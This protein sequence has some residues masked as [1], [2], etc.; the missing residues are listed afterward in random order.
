MKNTTRQLDTIERLTRLS[1]AELQRKIVEPILR[2]E[3]FTAVRQTSGPNDKGKDLIAYKEELGKKK[4]YAIQI[5]KLRISGK[6]NSSQGLMNLITQLRQVFSEPVADPLTM[7]RRFVDRAI[8]ITPYEIDKDAL[9]SAFHAAAELE[10]KD[11]AIIDGPMLADMLTKH[12]AIVSEVFDQDYRYRYLLAEKV[13]KIPESGA[14]GLSH[15]LLLRGLYVNVALTDRD[16]LIANAAF[17]KGDASPQLVCATQQEFQHL[18]SECDS[19]APGTKIFV[20]T[21]KNKSIQEAIKREKERLKQELAMENSRLDKRVEFLRDEQASTDREI[22]TD[23]A[24]TSFKNRMKYLAEAQPRYVNI[25]SVVEMI[26]KDASVAMKQL[27]APDF[28][29]K[30]VAELTKVFKQLIALNKRIR[31]FNYQSLIHQ[32]WPVLWRGGS[33]QM[34]RYPA[35]DASI[36]MKLRIPIFIQG[37]AGAG[38]ST[39]LRHLCQQ[40]DMSDDAEDSPLPI[41]IYLIQAHISSEESI[42]DQCLKQLHLVG[43]AIPEVEFRARLKRGECCVFFDG[44]DE[45]GDRSELVFSA[46]RAFASSNPLTLIVVTARDTY[47]YARWDDAVQL[48]INPFTPER[49]KDFIHNWF[50]SEPSKVATIQSWLSTN[51]KMRE[52]ASM[53]IIAALLCS[54]VGADA[55]LPGT[56]VELYEQRFELL[57]GRWEKAKG[58][59]SLPSLQRK[60]YWRFMTKVAYVMHMQTQRTILYPDLLRRAQEFYDINYHRTPEN[61]IKDCIH[62]GLLFQEADQQLSFGH[63]TYQEFLVAK[64]L[65]SEN[66]IEFILHRVEQPWWGKTLA[67]YAAL[68]G[69]VSALLMQAI[70]TKRTEAF[71][72][73]LLELC[74]QAVLTPGEAKERLLSAYNRPYPIFPKM[75]IPERGANTPAN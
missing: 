72:H 52:A 9:E 53:P 55:E 46:I 62:R 74:D 30:S 8:F 51:D 14:F 20:D 38:K 32:Y 44:L 36:L 21:S 58:G 24:V 28:P 12:R 43:H 13:N 63:L 67:F 15:D 27:A 48:R 70:T 59:Q 61:I 42:Y 39:L 22:E 56:E 69:D 68:K 54:L 10:R 71:L 25:S 16:S 73:R 29:D 7:T 18:Q 26:Q 75:P 34:F 47:E 17:S 45:V 57:L 33:P 4:L 35:L 3:G 41:L 19:W 5:K 60:R 49:L 50:T 31:H 6:H 66:P 23:N 2:S 65:E 11:I 37:G 40:I 1:E 64:H